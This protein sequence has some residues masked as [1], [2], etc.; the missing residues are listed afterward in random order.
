M[1][2]EEIA[3]SFLDLKIRGHACDIA[4]LGHMPLSILPPFGVA[5]GNRI[6]YR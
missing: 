4:I 6:V 3:G 5:S 2:G 1:I